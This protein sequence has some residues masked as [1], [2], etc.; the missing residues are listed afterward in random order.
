M[1]T[2]PAEMSYRTSLVKG[3]YDNML[4]YP[5]IEEI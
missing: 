4:K 5:Y 3:I 2:F 1:R